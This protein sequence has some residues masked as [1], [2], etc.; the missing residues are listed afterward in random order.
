MITR[1]RIGGAVV[2]ALGAVGATASAYLDWFGGQAADDI[3]LERLFQTEVSDQA[4]SY[5]NSVALPLAVVSLLGVVGAILLSRFVLSLGWLIGV[6]AL[7]LWIVMQAIDD[8]ADF[9][10][11]DLEAGVWVC[12]ASLLVMIAGIVAMG[13]PRPEQVVVEAPPS[14]PADRDE[15]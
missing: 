9:S 7:V 8:G 14:T 4:S 2:A 5:W 15:I 11:G 1:Q 12:A 6:A 3:P 13:N 10:V